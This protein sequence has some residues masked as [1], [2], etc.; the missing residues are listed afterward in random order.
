MQALAK[1]FGLY[2]P[3][4]II[5]SMAADDLKKEHPMLEEKRAAAKARM[6]SFGR[7]SLLEGGEFSRKN[8]CLKPTNN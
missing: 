7:T 8:R 3:T 2:D 5:N 1:F 4:P 6:A